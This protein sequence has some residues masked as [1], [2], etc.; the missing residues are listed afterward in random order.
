MSKQAW[1]IICSLVAA[2]PGCS[3]TGTPATAP[4]ITSLNPA[5]GFI[6]TNQQVAI[7]GRNFANGAT[8]VLGPDTEIEV[9]NVQFASPQRL[10]VTLII[11]PNATPGRRNVTV[12]NPNGESVTMPV[13]FQTLG[14]GPVTIAGIVPNNGARGGQ[15]Q[16]TITGTNFENG[17]TLIG[18]PGF[19]FANVTVNS[20]SQI[21]A[22]LTIEATATLGAQN[23]GVANPNG[24][25]TAC[26]G[27]FMVTQ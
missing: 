20:V 24:F 4:V 7:N 12:T 17:A 15:I 11:P 13:A 27:C 9:G 25:G 26:E 10:N 2:I 22:Q 1:W 5:A 6:G 19:A 23:L 21:T 18:P 3:G 8:V 16:I 14:L